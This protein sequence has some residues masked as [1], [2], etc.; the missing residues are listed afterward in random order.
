M[1]K[2]QLLLTTPMIS[3]LSSACPRCPLTT[4]QGVW[5]WVNL[6]C[7]FVAPGVPG[8]TTL[9]QSESPSQHLPVEK[10]LGLL[11]NLELINR[12]LLG[13]GQAEWYVCRPFRSDERGLWERP[14]VVGGAAGIVTSGV[15]IQQSHSTLFGAV[16]HHEFP[17]IWGR[18]LCPPLGV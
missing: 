8:L 5:D 11:R 9:N 2:G 16:L 6:F 7:G 4:P 3:V 10:I 14:A 12:P 1:R 13:E 17:S 18:M 15:I